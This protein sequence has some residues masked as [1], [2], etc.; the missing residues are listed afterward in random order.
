MAK[1]DCFQSS[2]PPQSD[3]DKI[4]LK[5]LEKK[6]ITF[7]KNRVLLFFNSPIHLRYQRRIFGIN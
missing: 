2:E 5:F 4:V 3:V 6:T 7:W 1:A